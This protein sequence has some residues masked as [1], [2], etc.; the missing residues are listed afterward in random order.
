MF[1]EITI[2][3][4][5]SFTFYINR[6]YLKSYTNEKNHIYTVCFDFN[7]QSLGAKTYLM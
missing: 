7:K 2:H 1:S 3:S 6:I 4:L 5:S